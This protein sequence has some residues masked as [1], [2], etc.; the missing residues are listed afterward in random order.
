MVL[1]SLVNKP[2]PV[3]ASRVGQ[4]AP[5]EVLTGRLPVADGGATV[6]PWRDASVIKSRDVRPQDSRRV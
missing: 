3:K 1:R 4:D 2:P 5:S 6:R